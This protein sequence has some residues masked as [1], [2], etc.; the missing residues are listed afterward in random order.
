MNKIIEKISWVPFKIAYKYGKEAENP[1]KINLRKIGINKEITFYFP[2]K[3]VGLSKQLGTFGFREPINYE[4]YANFLNEKDVVLDIGANI[5]LFTILSSKANQ[6]IAVEPLPQ[7]MPILKKNI[8]ANGI[9]DKTIILN[10]AVGK[11]KELLLEIDPQLNLSR[12]VKEKNEK[13]VSVKS[14]PVSYLTKKY[15]ANVL[16]MDVEG[17]EYEILLNEIPKEVNKISIEFHV[18]ILGKEKVEELMN[19]FEKE[20]FKIKYLVEDLPLRLYP[21]YS[22]LKKTGLIKLVTY[23]KKELTPTEAYPL[24]LKGRTIKYLFLER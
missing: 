4:Y 12:I 24:L 9:K 15:G 18:Q 20:G 10:L 22:F 16:R 21:L 23:V 11:E 13:T 7:A 14:V 19:Y 2:E 3:D 17:Y 5:G 6:I 8:E 1:A